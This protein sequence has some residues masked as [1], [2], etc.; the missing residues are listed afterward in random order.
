M[1]RVIANE[2]S[3]SGF[4]DAWAIE[5]VFV[6]RHFNGHKNC[7]CRN[8]GSNYQPTKELQEEHE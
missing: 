5:D 7:D 8:N 1:Q 3:V 2:V 6:C 4:D